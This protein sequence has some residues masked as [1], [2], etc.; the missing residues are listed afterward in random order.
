MEN[1]QRTPVSER[2]RRNVRN[3]K[4]LL[5]AEIWS[6]LED[7]LWLGPKGVIVNSAALEDR[8]FFYRIIKVQN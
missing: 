3:S 5:P 6:Y 8:K 2:A 4:S 1:I 7:D